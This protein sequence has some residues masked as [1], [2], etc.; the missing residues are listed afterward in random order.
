M[1][2][3]MSMLAVAPLTSTQTTDMV[4]LKKLACFAPA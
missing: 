1:A 3:E 4:T 2:K